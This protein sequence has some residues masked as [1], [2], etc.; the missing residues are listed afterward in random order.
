MGFEIGSKILP[1]RVGFAFWSKVRCGFV[2]CSEIEG[3][4]AFWSAVGYDILRESEAQIKS[5]SFSGG[6]EYGGLI[7]TNQMASNRVQL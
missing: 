7:L 6:K 3:G 1:F 5:F 4:F 2:F